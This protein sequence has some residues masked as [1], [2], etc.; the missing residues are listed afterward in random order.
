MALP[1]SNYLQRISPTWLTGETDTVPRY[2]ERWVFGAVGLMADFAAEAVTL[3]VRA[4]WMRSSD[5]SPEALAPVATER[6]HFRAATDTDADFAERLAD[7]W[8]LFEF[9][10]NESIIIQEVE[11]L[12]EITDIEIPY[13]HRLA[14]PD[15]AQLVVAVLVVL[16]RGRPFGRAPK[17]FGAGETYGA[18]TPPVYGADTTAE[19][20]SALRRRVRKYKAGHEICR[21]AVFAN[22]PVYGE[23]GLTYG[24]GETYGGANGIIDC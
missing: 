6:S 10:G 12:S 20:A 19:F 24:G 8:T 23:G 14:D 13:P 7:A 16:C 4:A 15:A 18:T 5:L 22:G 17:T 9:V 1:F 3:A 11:R 21:F 2:G